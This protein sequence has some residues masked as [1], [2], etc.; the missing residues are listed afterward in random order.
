MIGFWAAV[1]RR[2]RHSPAAEMLVDGRGRRLSFAEFADRATRLAS[3]LAERGVTQGASVTWQLPTGID[4]LVLTAALA[5][6]GAVQ[7]PVITAQGRKH[8]EFVLHQTEATLLVAE[9]SARD[10]ADRVGVDLVRL[11]DLP[12]PGTRVAAAEPSAAT[13]WVF[14]TSGTTAEPKGARHTDASILASA[15]AMGEKLRCGP[16]DR[17][18]MVFPVAHIGGCGTWLGVSLCYGCTLVLDASFDPERSAALQRRERVTLAGSGTVFTQ[19]YLAVQRQDP[20][21]PLFPDAR[22]FTCGGAGRPATLHAEV[23][24]ELGGVG[25]LSGYGLTEAPILAMAAPDDPDDA[26]ATSEGTVGPGVD[27]R[28]VAPDGRLLGPNEVGELRVKGPQV[29]LGYVDARLDADAFDGEGYLRTGDLG[30]VDE[31]GY[32]RIT[33]RLKDVIIRKGET[34]SAPALEAELLAHA[35]VDDVAVVAVPDADRGEL[36]CAVI[37][38]VPGAPIPSLAEL[39]THLRERGLPARLCPELLCVVAALP[40]T[41][42]GKVRKDELRAFAS[43]SVGRG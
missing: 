20:S 4:A 42:T 24:R 38:P 28:A 19:S 36:A 5:R 16:A 12:D 26:R 30:R 33:G 7:N 34:I 11:G 27:L 3:A 18:G 41:S 32:L 31:A 37:V 10:A 40:R 39:V 13:R 43:G 8:L 25:V 21:R 6:L 15:R 29:M 14:Y 35:A 17:V 23:K 9:A 2:A 22:A 1:E